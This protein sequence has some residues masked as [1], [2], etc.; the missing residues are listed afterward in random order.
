MTGQ[1]NDAD[2]RRAEVERARRRAAS[3]S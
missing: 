2:K 1:N 3:L